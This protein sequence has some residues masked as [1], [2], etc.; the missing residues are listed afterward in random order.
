MGAVAL[1]M[2]TNGIVGFCGLRA[3]G[4]LDN[5][6]FYTEQIFKIQ[7]NLLVNKTIKKS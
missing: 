5:K 2:E 3:W 7:C 6:F 1:N 4:A